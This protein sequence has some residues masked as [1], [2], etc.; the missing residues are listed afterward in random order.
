[1]YGCFIKKQ[2]SHDINP[3]VTIEGSNAISTNGYATAIGSPLNPDTL[4]QEIS[5]EHCEWY[6][7]NLRYSYVKMEM[8]VIGD[9]PM[10]IANVCIDA[11][12]FR[13]F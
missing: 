4:V 1:M 9:E 7:E 2:G 13:C 3:V 11:R 6:V 5:H 12:D 10:I 8:S